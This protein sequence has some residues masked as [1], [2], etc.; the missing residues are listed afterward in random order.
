MSNLNVLV[1]SRYIKGGCRIIE[2]YCNGIKAHS[3]NYYY[4]DYFDK[5]S[6]DGKEK[7]EKQI[8]EIV[9]DKKIDC[10]FFILWSGDLTFDIYFIERLSKVSTIVMNFY[11]T[12][13]YFEGVDRYYAQLADLV[14]LP[15]CLARYKYEHLNINALTTFSMFDGNF[16]KKNH[17]INKSIDVSFVGSLNRSDSRNQYID[18][19][20]THGISVEIYGAG[21]D[22]GFVSFEEMV[23]IFNK[24]KINLN[25]TASSGSENYV[26]KPPII[27]QRIKQVKGRPIEIAL[28]GGF[29]LSEYAPGIEEMFSI[30][31]EMEVFNTKEELLQKI[32]YYLSNEKKMV[33]ISARGHESALTNYEVVA[34]FEK[35]FNRIKELKTRKTKTV[36]VDS[37]FLYNFVAYRFFYIAYFI[38]SGKFGNILD[39]L[40]TILKFR[41]INISKAYFFALKGFLLHTRRYPKLKN[42]LKGIKN[43]LK[44][45]EKY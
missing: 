1:L 24:S 11:D 5:Y 45:K 3:R 26:I 8:E 35:V 10:I 18:Y 40:R 20:K 27:N 33:E 30:G 39:E 14:I 25:F 12:E 41:K 9:L 43:K 23:A 17:S 21:S 37:E 31:R 29:I 6:I 32:Q 16:Y 38:L 4:V 22:H 44:M 36:Y 13:L 28:C 19:L 2:D 7:S 34:G 42:A 15:D